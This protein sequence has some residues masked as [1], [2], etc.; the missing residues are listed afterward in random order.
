MAANSIVYPCCALKNRKRHRLGTSF[1]I[2]A[3]TTE[4][5]GLHDTE[6]CPACWMDKKNELVEYMLYPQEHTNFP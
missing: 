6:F 4:I 5:G 2:A 3:G 1:G